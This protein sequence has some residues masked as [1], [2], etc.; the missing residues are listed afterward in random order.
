MRSITSLRAV[1]ASLAD[2]NYKTK[3]GL[4]RLL[5]LAGPKLPILPHPAIR[6]KLP[7]VENPCGTV[8]HFFQIEATS[9]NHESQIRS[10]N[11]V[12]RRR[13][14]A[15]PKAL[16]LLVLGSIRAGSPHALKSITCK[17]EC[18][19]KVTLCQQ[20]VCLLVFNTVGPRGD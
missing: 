12:L 2:M 7:R 8:W 6:S 14:L 15:L 16:N 10:E 1:P 5:G 13:D 4:G 19:R 18:G 9:W 3:R 11:H 20:I 17:V